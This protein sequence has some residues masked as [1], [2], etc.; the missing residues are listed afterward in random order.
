[1]LFESKKADNCFSDAENYEY[2]IAVIGEE[3]IKLL[4]DLAV[5]V[6][7]NDKLRR[8][9]F[10]A[11]LENGT[12]IKGV[13]AKSTIKVGYLLSAASEQK[14]CFEQWLKAL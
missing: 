14:E 3:F 13:L 9:V 2:R 8:P 10:M 6:R 1:M 4:N 12:R 11:E 7:I 5:S